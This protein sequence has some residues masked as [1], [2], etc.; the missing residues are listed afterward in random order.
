MCATC[1]EEA[2]GGGQAVVVGLEEKAQEFR[3]R[4]SE[5]YLKAE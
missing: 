4:G 1:G 5:L 3:E 2:V